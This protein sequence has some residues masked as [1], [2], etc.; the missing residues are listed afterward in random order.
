MSSGACFDYLDLSTE[1]LHTSEI[2]TFHTKIT[3]LVHLNVYHSYSL[4]F[5]QFLAELRAFAS[6]EKYRA[7]IQPYSK[8]AILGNNRIHNSLRGLCL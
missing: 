4:V 8:G 6:W 5:T 1:T 7:L 3:R 2:L